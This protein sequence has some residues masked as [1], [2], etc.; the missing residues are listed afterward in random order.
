M[1]KPVSIE[2]ADEFVRLRRS[3]D[4]REYNRSAHE[5]ASEDVW[6][7]VLERFPDMTRWVVHNKTVPL[8]LLKRLANHAD[9]DV[10]WSVA[11][12][13]KLDRETFELLAHDD[14]PEVRFRVAWNAKVP[15]DL[16]ASLAADADPGVAE[17]AI[18]R[19]EVLP[20]RKRPR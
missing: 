1:F 20:E 15:Y 2:S 18:H 16:L 8:D 17:A 6:E 19:L 11:G 14:E 7:D 5:A 12:K 9:P 4:P 13:R 10:R 3:E